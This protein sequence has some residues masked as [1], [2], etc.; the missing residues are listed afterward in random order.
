MKI[1]SNNKN[2][3][4]ELPEVRQ[5]PG[6]PLKSRKKEI[7]EVRRIEKLSK[8][9]VPMTCSI[10]KGENHNKKGCPRNFNLKY[11]LAPTKEVILS[12]AYLRFY[13]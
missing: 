2:S 1:C 5:M 3:I 7:D 12:L 13:H 4:V 8:F 6:R 9:W 10:C 11:T